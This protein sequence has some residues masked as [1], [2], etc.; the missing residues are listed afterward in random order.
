MKKI[1]LASASARRSDLLKQVGLDF[2][3]CPSACEEHSTQTDPALYVEE[4]SL[5]KATEVSLRYKNDS[6]SSNDIVLGA[7]TIVAYQGRILG[8]PQ[9]QEHALQ[10]LSALQ[11]QI[12][13]VFT[14]VT[15]FSINDSTPP[16]TFSVKTDVEM[17]PAS[18]DELIAY[19][20]TGEPMD[21]A[22]AYGIQRGAAAFIKEIRGDYNNVVGLP[23]SRVY[24]ELKK[25]D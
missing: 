7:D 13:Q 9:N 4:L 21:K 20:A 18:K 12:H 10:M 23:L 25:L 17:Y 22:G 14:G 11:G 16:I 24:Q 19:I 8:K 3:I 1:I 6:N 2:I 5:Q 15:L